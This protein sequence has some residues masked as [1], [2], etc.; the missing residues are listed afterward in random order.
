[1]KIPRAHVPLYLIILFWSRS[2]FMSSRAALVRETCQCDDRSSF[3]SLLN[4]IPKLKEPNGREYILK[5]IRTEKMNLR[6]RKLM[7]CPDFP[8]SG[9]W[10]S[11]WKRFMLRFSFRAA[12]ENRVFAYGGLF[13][14]IISRHNFTFDLYACNTAGGLNVSS[15]HAAIIMQASLKVARTLDLYYVPSVSLSKFVHFRTIL[16]TKPSLSEPY[17]LPSLRAPLSDPLA[18][19][20]FMGILFSTAATLM[21]LRAKLRNP[22][23]AV[24]LLLSG[25]IGQTLGTGGN[26]KF[27]AVYA[28][29]LLLTGFISVTYTTILRSI[30]VVPRVR[31]NVLPFKE[32][33][34]RNY[35]FES[36]HWKWI[37]GRSMVDTD[38]EFLSA[39]EELISELVTPKLP[40]TSV[41]FTDYYN[42]VTRTVLVDSNKNTAVSAGITG[43]WVGYAGR[44]RA[45]L[46]CSS[47]V[48]FHTD[49]VGFIDGT[50]G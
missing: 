2:N 45:F 36:P 37:K 30:V 21:I 31:Y 50:I 38:D 25:M 15:N 48:G 20:A 40:G 18:L 3:V 11:K 33:A 19:I 10:K 49:S 26:S 8:L 23:E 12:H 9:T 35:N 46:Q 42:E 24:L 13:E 1:M 22:A 28:A 47:L 43:E 16:F 4:F 5:K 27:L 29:W 44:E 34:K 39:T 14:S 6:G 7:V 17:G 32:M 41:S